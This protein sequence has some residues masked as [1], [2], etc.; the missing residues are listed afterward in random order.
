MPRHRFLV[1]LS[2]LCFGTTGTAQALGAAGASPV[3]VGEVRIVIGAL[4]LQVAARWAGRARVP[5]GS[6]ATVALLPRSPRM[7]MA[8][9]AVAGYQVTFFLAVRSTGV[10][11]GTVVALG[12]APVLTGALG[13]ILGHGRPGRRWAAATG[14][15]A[16]GLAVLT[17]HSGAARISTTGVVLALGAGVSYAVYTLTVKQAIGSGAGPEAIMATLFTGGALLLAPVLIVLPIGWLAT[18]GGALA[19]VWLGLVP[20]TLAY[21]LFARGLHGLSA[22]E[23]ST[24]TLA[25]PLTAALLGVLLLS[26]TLSAGTVAGA[27]L[28]LLGLVVLGISR[29]P[30]SGAGPGAAPGPATTPVKPVNR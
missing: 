3:T 1:L 17:L 2:A 8:A 14:L 27:A 9:A 7:W 26:E 24:L 19:A 25:E 21:V 23:A 11:V 13:W 12:S 20:T 16:A 10:A 5:G 30:S 4:G 29:R 18:A 28:L 15:A 22:A 6:P